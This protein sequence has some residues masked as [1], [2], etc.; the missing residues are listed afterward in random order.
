MAFFLFRYLLPNDASE[1]EV[2][3]ARNSLLLLMVLFENM[4]IGNCR[5][6]TKSVFRLSPFKSP[7]LVLGTLSA[8]T[9]HLLAM[10]SHLGQSLLG[11]QA[12]AAKQ[13]LVLLGLAF[14]IIPVMELHKFWWSRRHIGGS[15]RRCGLLRP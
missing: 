2:S 8:F 10:H 9:I 1:A 15:W 4:H 12:I 3:A 14:L 7:V 6:E 13:W 5:S 11:T